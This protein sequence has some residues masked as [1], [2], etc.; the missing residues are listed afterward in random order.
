[1]FKYICNSII[2]C[3]YMYLNTQQDIYSYTYNVAYYVL[4]Y[5]LYIICG[6]VNIGFIL[7][8]LPSPY[9]IQILVIIT[10]INIRIVLSH[11]VLNTLGQHITI[12]IFI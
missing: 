11:I 8:L 10:Y 12:N 3:T 1:M 6:C 9:N 7:Y 4:S 5:I 2:V